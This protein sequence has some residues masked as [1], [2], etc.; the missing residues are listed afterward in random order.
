M[1]VVIELALSTYRRRICFKFQA[2]E[3]TDGIVEICGG[4]AIIP[5]GYVTYPI[6][7]PSGSVSTTGIDCSATPNEVVTP[8]VCNKANNNSM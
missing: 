4:N 3:Q 8:K 2:N 5:R 7:L 6:S 1:N